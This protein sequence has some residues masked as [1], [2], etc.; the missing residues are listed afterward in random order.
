MQLSGTHVLVTGASRGIGAEVAREAARRGAR[1]TLVAR[2]AAPLEALAAETGGT[3]LPA[4]LGDRDTRRGLVARAEALNGTVDV[5]VNVASLD[6]AGSFLALDA[7]TLEELLTVNLT[8][9]AELTRQ[10]LPA[11]V[12]RGS[13]HVVVFSSG[14]STV[15]A[16][17]LA[18]YC[19]SK[20]GLPS[21]PASCAPSSR[22]A[23]S[24]SPWSSRAR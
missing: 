13:G 23:A 4:D 3:A 5:L 6:A 8:A 9:G 14:F 24:G 16:P 15:V 22:A 2:S 12:A 21:S 1:L 18:A 20:G 11:M 10:V 7:D 19:A 17:G